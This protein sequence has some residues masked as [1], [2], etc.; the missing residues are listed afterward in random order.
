MNLAQLILHPTTRAALAHYLAQPTQTLL[1]T[2]ARGVGLKTIAQSL[3]R[4]IAGAS[5]ALIE[6]TIHP[7]KK[8][9]IITADDFDQVVQLARDR[10]VENFAIVIDDFDRIALG[11]G[12]YEK[13]LKNLEEPGAHIFYLLTSHSPAKLP[14]TIRSRAQ[15]VEVLPPP[16]SLIEP[17]FTQ[18]LPH[19]L[20]AAQ[21]NQIKFLGQNFPAE[22]SRLLQDD[23]Y[24]HARAARMA[25]AKQFLQ[26]N[27]AERLRIVTENTTRD[28]ARE[29]TAE[30][31][32]LIL[33]SLPKADPRT[34]AKLTAN[35][36]VAH[37]VIANLTANGNSRAQLLYLA[38]NL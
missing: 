6:P 11:G 30:I 23:E 36:A 18:N 9:Q 25:N 27:L 4:A 24:F 12:V 28:A 19:K 10:R 29:L 5:V 16:V 34:A 31:A 35:L 15:T 26:G 37:D 2:G 7:G 1:L 22:I 32:R 21:L 8:M 13:L 14:A 33:L 3:A 17:M 20:T 38:T